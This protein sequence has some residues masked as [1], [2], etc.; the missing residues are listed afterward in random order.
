MIIMK[1][2]PFTGNY[3]QVIL[4]ADLQEYQSLGPQLCCHR[5]FWWAKTFLVKIHQMN[6]RMKHQHLND[7]NIIS[8]ER[9]KFHD[10][11]KGQEEQHFSI[12]LDIT[13]KNVD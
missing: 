9:T 11:K 3:I 5:R 10:K 1:L 8:C 12:L 6:L 2:C 13:I 4:L 7:L